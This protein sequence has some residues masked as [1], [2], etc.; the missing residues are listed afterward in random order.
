MGSDTTPRP[1]PGAPLKTLFAY[2]Y[3]TRNV[4]GAIVQPSD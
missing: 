1:S 3:N 2:M 4:R